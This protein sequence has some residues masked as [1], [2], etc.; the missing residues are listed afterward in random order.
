MKVTY[1]AEVGGDTWYVYFE[2]ERYRMVGYRFYHD[3]AR[4]DG[5]YIVLEGEHAIGGM[6]IP[7]RRSWYVNADGRYL[8]TD[9]LIGDRSVR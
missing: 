4:G 8:G 2:P 3:E 7:A 1:D 9:E 5:E 6:R